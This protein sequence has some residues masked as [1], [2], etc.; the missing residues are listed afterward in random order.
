MSRAQFTELMGVLREILAEL[1]EIK[2]KPTN[3]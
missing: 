1:K 3:K 2:Q